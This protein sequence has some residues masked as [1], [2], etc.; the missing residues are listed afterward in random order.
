MLKRAEI[1]VEGHDEPVGCT[2]R[3]LS[4]SG[5]MLRFDSL[6]APPERFV[7]RILETDTAREAELRWQMDRDIG[8]RFLAD[9]SLVT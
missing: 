5:A 3:N 1:V 9:P 7:L 4:A 2:I 6:F 8:V